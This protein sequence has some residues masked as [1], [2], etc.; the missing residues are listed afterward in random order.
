[1]LP[2]ALGE[3]YSG[4]SCA[5]RES[6]LFE[7]VR[8]AHR[9]VCLHC[10]WSFRAACA[11]INHF[12]AVVEAEARPEGPDLEHAMVMERWRC[13]AGYPVWLYWLGVPLLDSRGSVSLRVGYSMLALLSWLFCVALPA[14][15]S[16]ET[17]R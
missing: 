12:P 15:R 9:Q 5:I 8:D 11:R 13:P 6:T 14:L 3:S 4:G 16:A 7:R 17:A 2:A 10:G 1:M